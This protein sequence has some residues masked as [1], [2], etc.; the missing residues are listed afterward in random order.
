MKDDTGI[1]IPVLLAAAVVG[2]QV[3]GGL[4]AYVTGAVLVTWGVVVLLTVGLLIGMVV[5]LERRWAAPVRKMREVAAELG[6][7]N[8]SAHAT[9]GGAEDVTELAVGI[10]ALAAKARQQMSELEEQWRVV[11]ALVDTLPDPVMLVEGHRRVTLVN[12]AA[13]R[14]LGVT[15]ARAVG[16]WLGEVVKDRALL[17]TFEAVPAVVAGEAPAPPIERQVSVEREGGQRLTYQAVAVQ[18][19]DGVLLVLRDVTALAETVRI[20]TDFVANASHELRTPISA[21][22][23]AF[24]TLREVYAEDPRQTERCVRIIEGHLRR[25]E[26]ML[27]DLLDLSR[28]ESPELKVEW[29]EVRPAEVFATARGALGE[30]ATEKGVEL[31]AAGGNGAG[32]EPFVADVRLLNM[33]VKNLVENAIKFTPVG[34]FVEVSVGRSEG[35]TV[36][37]SVK[38]TGMGIPAEH[39]NRVFERFYQVDPAR[40]GSA[41]RGTGLGL[42]IV[43]HA[44]GAMGGTVSIASKMGE[45]TTVTCTFPQQHAAEPPY[46]ADGPAAVPV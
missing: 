21:I 24:E 6:R 12:S 27:R 4:V 15:P 28:L 19:A 22:K 23:A 20:K 7:G 9:P 31:R 32:E 40:T 35:G 34:G 41:G 2:V 13:G 3:I 44:V 5:A 30:M 45:G 14:L 46:R 33:V 18:T 11:Q 8:W 1:R 17:E 25:L 39:V 26:E 29:R 10:N 43:K 42:A 36:L 37:L 38:D 16:R